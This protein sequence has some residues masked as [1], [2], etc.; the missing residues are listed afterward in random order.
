MIPV[1]RP[2]VGRQEIEAVKKVFENRWLGMGA[3]TKEF[4]EALQE[5]LGVRYVVAVNSGTSALHLA[6]DSLNLGVNDEVIVPS[7]TFVAS[8]QAVLAVGAKP[9]F[10]DVCE[11]SMNMDVEDVRK[12]ITPRTKAVMPVHYGGTSCQM[13]KLAELAEK[14]G[15]MIVEDAAHAFG[16]EFRGKKVGSIGNIT[17]FSFDP[18]KNITCGEGG[19]VVAQDKR[20]MDQVAAKR[21]LGITRDSWSRLS[22]GHDWFY[23]VSAQ[24]Y[25]YHMSNINAA[26]GLEQIKRFGE[27][28]K[29]KQNIVRR[30]DEALGR[31]RGLKLRKHGS[32]SDFPFFYVIR[33]SE[34][35]R[36]EMMDYLRAKKIAS[37]LHYI[38]NHLHSFF[39][40]SRTSLPVTE[41][42]YSEILTLPLFYEMTDDN[43]EHV[44]AAIEAFFNES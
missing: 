24:G 4:E 16:S 14:E 32:G 11:D 7:L 44:I 22:D 23:N 10:C 12:R 33:I 17:C 27:F 20:F 5:S 31:I 43:V 1:Q 21:S 38:P 18:I 6:L 37:G 34:G 26:I 19:A 39:S 15:L 29:R 42:L 2:C 36:N 25:R 30:Y 28:K 13:D 8:I 41:R 9:V 35:R 40:D 3:F